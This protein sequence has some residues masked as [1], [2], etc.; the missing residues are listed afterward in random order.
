M[1]MKVTH[2]YVDLSYMHV[3]MLN[4]SNL[5]CREAGKDVRRAMIA[6]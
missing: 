2:L 6:L 5:D 1:Y 4:F 3:R